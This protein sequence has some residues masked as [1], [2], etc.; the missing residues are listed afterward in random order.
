[1][2]DNKSTVYDACGLGED[3]GVAHPNFETDNVDYRVGGLRKSA[4]SFAICAFE[5]SC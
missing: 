3:G 2:Y 1:M 4:N 5:G